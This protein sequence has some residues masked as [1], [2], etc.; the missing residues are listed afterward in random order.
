MEAFGHENSSCRARAGEKINGWFYRAKHLIAEVHEDPVRIVLCTLL[1]TAWVQPVS[2]P[3]HPGPSCLPAG[4]GVAYWRRAWFVGEPSF[5]CYAHRVV[6]QHGW[7]MANCRRCN[8]I[9]V[10]ML[11]AEWEGEMDCGEF[12]KSTT[13]KNSDIAFGR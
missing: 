2:A 7:T 8:R 5:L 9:V 4:V 10:Q 13:A 6:S 12:D 1:G 3:T 11:C